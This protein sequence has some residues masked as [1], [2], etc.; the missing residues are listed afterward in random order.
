MP[1]Q[2]P[3]QIPRP[4]LVRQ[5]DGRVLPEFPFGNP[6]SYRAQ[7]GWRFEDMCEALEA[8]GLCFDP[9]HVAVDRHSAPSMVTKNH[10]MRFYYREADFKACLV[11]DL[12]TSNLGPTRRE[13]NGVLFWHAGSESFGNACYEAPH[14]RSIWNE[15]GT[16]FAILVDSNTGSESIA[17]GEVLHLVHPWVVFRDTA[18]RPLASL[19]T[20]LPEVYPKMFDWPWHAR[21]GPFSRDEIY[22]AF[23]LLFKAHFRAADLYGLRGGWISYRDVDVPLPYPTSFSREQFQEWGVRLE[24][25]RR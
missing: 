5:A 16:T 19:R 20:D 12:A 2:M 8:A 23:Q 7:E 25:S 15:G 11:T 24:P 3:P 6:V 1:L 9:G 22:T 18:G 4:T 17:T 13:F 21:T 10:F 14:L